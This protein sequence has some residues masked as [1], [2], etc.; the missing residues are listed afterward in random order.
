MSS[1]HGRLPLSFVSSCFFKLLHEVMICVAIKIDTLVG[2]C[3]IL[4]RCYKTFFGAYF[5]LG[6]Q[7]SEEFVTHT[8]IDLN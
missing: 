8:E 4:L 1:E 3:S 5:C 7:R 6:F 2:F